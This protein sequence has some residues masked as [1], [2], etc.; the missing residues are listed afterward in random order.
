MVKTKSEAKK[1][2]QGN[3]SL[4]DIMKILLGDISETELAKSLFSQNIANTI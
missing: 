2:T 4:I 1:T 3:P